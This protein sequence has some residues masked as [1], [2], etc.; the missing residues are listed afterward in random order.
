[1]NETILIIDDDEKL[2]KLL[3]TYLAKFSFNVV[4]AITPTEGFKTLKKASPS[5][6]ILDVMLPEMDGFEVLKQIRK[7]SRIP[8]IMLTARGETTDTVLGLEMGA[9]DYL[10]KPFEPRE[11]VARIQS[12]LRRTSTAIPS[13]NKIIYQE[14]TVDFNKRDALIS[15]NQVLLTSME[16]EVLTI[17]VKNPGRVFDRDQLM[18]KL[19]GIDLEVFDRSVD[20]LMSRLRKKLGDNPK[21]PTFFKTVYGAGYIF[22]GN[23]A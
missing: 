6:I 14:L 5:L 23:E 4:S 3:T 20:V 19:K 22:I 13:E 18:D 9:D 16:F 21:N 15:G 1:M 11:L 17:F 7:D 10:P 12:V 2:N 8:I